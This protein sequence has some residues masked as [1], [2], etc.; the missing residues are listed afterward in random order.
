MPQPFEVTIG[1][2]IVSGPVPGSHLVR[3]AIDQI[4]IVVAANADRPARDQEIDGARRR[5]ADRWRRR[6]D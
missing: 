3:R 1:K 6:R 2:L 5:R 4:A